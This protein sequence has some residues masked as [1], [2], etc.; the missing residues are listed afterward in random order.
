M[1]HQKICHTG[2]PV[3]DFS[4]ITPLIYAGNNMCCQD[5]FDKGLLKKGVKADISLE[6]ERIDSPSG[7]DYFLWLP[8]KDHYPPTAKQI[9]LGGKFLDGLVKN[10]IKTYI[11]CKNGHTR[12]GTFL[13]SYLIMK[14]WALKKAFDFINKKR[15]CTHITKIQMDFLKKFEKNYFRMLK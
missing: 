7:V 1:H 3:L 5:M 6:G 14:G 15:D 12:T 13:I 11:H 4:Q 8:V 10:K 2:N 9:I